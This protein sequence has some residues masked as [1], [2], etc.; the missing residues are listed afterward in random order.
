MNR[1]IDDHSVDGAIHPTLRDELIAAIEPANTCGALLP[2]HANFAPDRDLF[3]KE[4][5]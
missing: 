4:N 5:A 1:A 3:I 2:L